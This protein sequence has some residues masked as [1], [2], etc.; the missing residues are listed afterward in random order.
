MTS[1][2]VRMFVKNKDEVGRSEVRQQY[3]MLSSGVGIT[4]NILLFVVKFLLGIFSH[5]VAV[6]ADAFN[7]LSDVGSAAITF[8]GF[9]M[10]N[11]PADEEH[12]FGHGRIEYL[13]GMA[14]TV[15]ILLVG[16]EILKTSIEKIIHPEP[17]FFN[18]ITIVA[19]LLS[20]LLKF[21][22]SR[23]HHALGDKIHS[24]TMKAAAQDS[25]NDCISSGATA[26]GVVLAYFFPSYPLDG[27]LGVMA[28]LFVLY[29]GYGIAKETI[30]PLLGEA[31]DPGLVE[32]IKKIL[33][34]YDLILG[35][36][37][38]VIHDYGP[39]RIMGSAHV[40]IPQDSSLVKA[41]DMIDNAEKK[42]KSRLKL[43]FVLHLDPVTTENPK[44]EVL[45]GI[46]EAAVESVD[47][48]MSIH[49]FRI[50][51]GPTHTNLIFDCVVPFHFQGKN[52]DIKKAVDKQL[53]D[54][55]T[56]YHTVISYDRS[57]V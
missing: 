48:D 39:G 29:A 22:M 55:D 4:C 34:S 25:L 26:A 14:L 1:F 38:L 9:R 23:F 11:R 35:V 2:L 7:N 44:V 28:G 49:D 15:L 19:L 52:A 51:E 41:H 20:I 37:D 47:K 43:E 16:V 12:P 36:H 45:K 5:S 40:E 46:V 24:Q 33:F 53:E 50:V 3:G 32:E 6:T 31:P 30:N 8:I 18:V 21:W 54:M 10:A 56:V 13:S 57:Y 27:Y 42:I 17:V